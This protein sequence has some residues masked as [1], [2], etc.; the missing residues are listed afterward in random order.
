VTASPWRRAEDDELRGLLGQAFELRGSPYST[1]ACR[2]IVDWHE[3]RH[4]RRLE[5]EQEEQ[6]RLHRQAGRGL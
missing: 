1:D 2:A 6:A 3:R 5:R 4:L